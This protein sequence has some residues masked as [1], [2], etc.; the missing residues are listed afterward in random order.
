MRTC[1][2]VRE[3]VSAW[4]DGEL[5]PQIE[6]GMLEHTSDCEECRSFLEICRVMSDELTL[7]EAPLPETLIPGVMRRL[8][9]ERQTAETGTGTVRTGDRRRTY[10]RIAAWACAA[11]CLALVIIAGPW[12]WRAGSSGSKADMAADMA[13]NE[14]EAWPADGGKAE[15]APAAADAGTYGQSDEA[16][17]EM[18]DAD[19]AEVATEEAKEAFP[20]MPAE[21][22]APAAWRADALLGDY[23][24]VITVYGDVPESVLALSEGMEETPDGTAWLI[25]P[26]MAEELS[27]VLEKS[28]VAYEW[29][30]G[31]GETSDWLLVRSAD[32]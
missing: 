13:V 11:A 24:A 5:D 25:P 9:E 14:T 26:D 22:S 2:D 17:Y 18:Y 29:L 6:A 7:D 28:G 31:G 15:T 32:N 3:A 20:D 27:A 10:R 16:K 4:L 23:A 8:A 30:S 1:E 12:N 21:D 19:D